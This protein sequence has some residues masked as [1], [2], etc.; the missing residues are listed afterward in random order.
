MLAAEALLREHTDAL[1]CALAN[2]GLIVPVPRSLGLWGQTAIEGR[3]VIHVV[4]AEDRT[5]VIEAWKRVKSEGTARAAVRL[6]SRP[7]RWMTLHFLDLQSAHGVYLCALLPTHATP[8]EDGHDFHEAPP[9]ARFCTLT[10]NDTGVVL[11][12]DDAFTEMFGFAAE[13]VIG[14]PVLDQIHPDDH[15][16]AVEA[17]MAMLSTRRPQRVRARRARKDGGFLWVDMTLHNRLNEPDRNRVLV[18]IA[19]VS[20]EVLASEAR[21]EQE[22]LLRRLTDSI[23]D[24]VL[25]V[26]SSR[27]VRSHNA[28]LLELLH[29]AP[30]DR[31]ASDTRASRS[32]PEEPAA[33][34]RPLA[35][36]LG[37]LTPEGLRA[38]DAALDS[39]LD[40]SGDSELEV[41]VAPPSGQPARVLVNMHAL[42]APNGEV[43]GA[44]IRVIEN[45]AARRRA[46]LEP[47]NG[48]GL[49]RDDGEALGNE[50]SAA[51]RSAQ[52][53][54]MERRLA[55][56]AR[57]HDAV[58]RLGQI[59]L[60]QC[61]MDAFV[62]EVVSTV[63]ETLDLGL[64][65]VLRLRDA[66]DVLDVVGS[67]GYPRRPG[68]VPVGNT[69]AG[70]TLKTREPVVSEDLRS[71][72]RF[73]AKMPLEKGMLSGVTTV[74][75]G[76]ER[77]FGVLS[78]FTT[79][80]RRFS[81]DD[82]NFLVAVANLISAAVERERNDEAAR[83]A[84]MHDPLTGLPNR[85]LALDRIDRAL[86]RRRRDGTDVA[87]LLL[88]LDRFKIIN[89]SL[90]HDAGD[91]VLRALGGRLQETVRASDTIARL[92]G[93]EFLVV[94][95]RTAGVRTVIEQ[96][97]RII[98]AF[99]RPV[100]LEAGEH[101]LTVSIGI[102]IAERGDETSASLL[103]DA[104]A[105]MY[106][107][108]GRGPGRYELFEATVRDQVL[109]RLRTETELR[110]A[111]DRDQLTV[112]YQPIIDARDGR[113]LAVEAL[114]RWEHPDHGLVLPLDFI[115]IAEETGLI[116]E[117]GRRVLEAACRQGATWQ[118]R[119]EAPLQMFV[120]VSGHQLADPRFPAEV[121]E[122]AS[123]SGL[124]EGTLGLEVTES[125]LI[126]EGD[127]SMAVLGELHTLGLRLM[128]DDFGTGYSSLGHLRRFPLS[129]VKVDRSF[130]DGLGDKPR[131]IAIMRAI[132]EMSRALDL[133]VVAEGVESHP[134]LQQLRELD[135]ERVQGCLLCPPMGAEKL[136]EFLDDRLLAR[137]VDHAAGA[138][139]APPPWPAPR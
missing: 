129:G 57:Q 77:P 36:L 135:C 92:S 86:A 95:E 51:E 16:R 96:A 91:E 46:E 31:D 80:R 82:V 6:R 126:G 111:L 2:D 117:L 25:H 119:Y 121:C 87:V 120:N 4:V 39:V 138:V 59:A 130:I 118:Q 97:E 104:D 29:G 136:A 53:S 134:Q 112:H 58:A 9:A 30:A 83:H 71:E 61:E 49:P 38:F 13:D 90:G 89:D 128:L 68:G 62:D 48:E 85:T 32:Q 63:R 60:R 44:L 73:E 10:E 113:P 122:I 88:D 47:R 14:K 45:A 1:V 43:T 133:T 50:A 125:V 56:H 79:Q 42:S 76:P 54:D 8:E 3:A 55:N 67:A 35:T 81:Q 28:R 66:E 114:V 52:R 24:G 84:A 65:G 127:S 115:P 5:V 132:V 7:S 19:D 26:D 102:A 105:A 72:T 41:E 109:A 93:D 18:E 137:G 139:L 100:S 11:D 78:A 98:A 123:A 37:A 17:W 101:V 64:C 21:A 75:E 131:D 34:E 74:I 12:C 70:Y 40:G 69:Q 106:Q 107:A 124:L 99:K 108:K 116:V 20:A 94:S 27:R 103:R 15:A 110:R 22:R 23:P 33:S